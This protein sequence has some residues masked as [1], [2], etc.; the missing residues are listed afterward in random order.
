MNT[1]KKLLIAVVLALTLQS[2]YAQTTS[3]RTTLTTATTQSTGTET[4]TVGS[5]TGMSASP[6]SFILIDAEMMQV[7]SVP[8]S[9][10]ITVRRATGGTASR[11]AATAEVRWG[12]S[13]QF[14]NSTGNT[15]GVFVGAA[16][17]GSCT[18]ASNQFLPVFLVA[19]GAV[20]AYDCPNTVSTTTGR[21]ISWEYYPGTSEVAARTTPASTV[22]SYTALVSDYYIAITTAFTPNNTTFT[23]TLP[24]ASVPA[25]KIWIVGDEGGDVGT[26]GNGITI[27]GAL[28]D[29]QQILAGFTSRAY[30]SNGT[31][32]FRL[33]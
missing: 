32:C 22:T 3:V 8:S 30:R 11:H 12:V 27:T 1:L 25:G 2:G 10:T 14:N 21:W 17:V 24:C 5:T 29:S 4:L 28:L 9:T 31:N 19:N 16:P 26:T 18:R 6:Q 15:S 23:V 13:G 33:W 7:V 20:T